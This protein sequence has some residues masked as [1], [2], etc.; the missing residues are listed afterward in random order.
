MG[1]VQRRVLGACKEDLQPPVLLTPP[2]AC[3]CLQVLV[4]VDDEY[5]DDR[6]ILP[7]LPVPP[8]NLE[9]EDEDED[10]PG[11]PPAPL[12]PAAAVA[13]APAPAPAPA[14]A[15]GVN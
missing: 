12:Q 8:I 3:Y 13:V 4:M 9:A 2:A 7:L 10:A 1:C 5:A 11:L 15:A 14:A 6:V